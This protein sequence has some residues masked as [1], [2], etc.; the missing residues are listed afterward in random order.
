MSYRLL[1]LP[2]VAVLA[3]AAMGCQLHTRANEAGF[4]LPPAPSAATLP[5]SVSA[6]HVQFIGSKN[7]LFTPTRVSFDEMASCLSPV[8]GS[9]RHLSAAGQ[10]L[11]ADSM[12]LVYHDP[13]EDPSVPF[14]LEIGVPIRGAST[15]PPAG[16]EVR[17]LPAFYC[18]TLLYRGPVKLLGKAYDKL[19]REMIE[20]GLVPSEETRESYLVWDSPDSSKNVVQIEVGIR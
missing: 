7:Y 6:M 10:I 8:V 11:P 20:R 13:S 12:L 4:D 15:L 5:Y 1:I 2:V 3:F 17:P 14:D 18:A 19:I 9:I 16:F